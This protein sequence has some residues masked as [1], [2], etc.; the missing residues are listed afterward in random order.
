MDMGFIQ[1]QADECICIQTISSNI[2][3]IS[4]YVNN[5]GILANTQ[6][7]LQDV[8]RSLNE[9]FTMTD[10]GPMEKILGIKVERDQQA[11]TIR[12]SQGAYID[13]VLNRFGMEDANVLIQTPSLS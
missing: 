2:E 11:R 12:I 8:K 7:G 6:A 9:T 4:I 10:L 5:L 3:I 1:S 13:T